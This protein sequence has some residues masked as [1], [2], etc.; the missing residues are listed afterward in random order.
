MIRSARDRHV[1]ALDALLK[2]RM[3]TLV[4]ERDWDLLAEVA[5]LAEQDAPTDL[6]VTDPAL[7]KAWRDAVTRYHRA[8]WT[9]M[10]PDRVREVTG[11][12]PSGSGQGT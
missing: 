3:A 4:R 11:A 6:S 9:N 5:R 12:D 8:G 10:T 2:G 7:F 1:E